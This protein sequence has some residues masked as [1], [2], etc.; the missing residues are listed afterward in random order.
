MV[1]DA[2]TLWPRQLFGAIT[3]ES[4]SLTENDATA[5]PSD[6]LQHGKFEWR[7][8]VSWPFLLWSSTL[9]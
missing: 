6:R 7:G 9:F 5:V 1:D 3:L 8:L 4:K 2:D